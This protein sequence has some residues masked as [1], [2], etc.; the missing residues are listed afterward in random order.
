ML[1]SHLPSC[2]W[3]RS[4]LTRP[5]VGARK[6]DSKQAADGRGWLRSSATNFIA[7]PQ[8]FSRLPNPQYNTL[9][10]SFAFP[11]YVAGGPLAANNMKCQLKPVDLADYAVAF[12]SVELTRLHNIFPNGVCDWSKPGLNKTG[13]VPWASFGPAPEN[14]IFDITKL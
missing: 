5:I 9:F 3:K 12:T 10:P 7:E 2:G 14:L 6:G 4:P 1:I 13:V 8:T 11:R